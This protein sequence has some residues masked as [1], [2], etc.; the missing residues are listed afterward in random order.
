MNRITE[1]LTWLGRKK[2]TVQDINQA[3]EGINL[4]YYFEELQK[5]VVILS[6]PADA[7]IEAMGYGNVGEEM[8]IDFNMSYPDKKAELTEAGLITKAEVAALEE[9]DASFPDSKVVDED[10][11]FDQQRLYTDPYWEIIRNKAMAARTAMGLAEVRLKVVVDEGKP[12]EN[13]L[14]MIRI[15][16]RLEG[17][18]K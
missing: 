11:W 17:I 6:S 15:Q 5:M 1:F 10:F 18:E 16:I 13:G 9:L 12:D 14:Q 7:Q 8:A 4:N 3:N 2:P